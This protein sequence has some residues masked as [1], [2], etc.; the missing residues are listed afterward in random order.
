MT[1]CNYVVMSY[2]FSLQNYPEL[3]PEVLAEEQEIEK[4]ENEVKEFLSDQ[5]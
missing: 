2:Y 3:T 4:S 1:R 5:V